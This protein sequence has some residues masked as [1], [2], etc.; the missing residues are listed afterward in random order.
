LGRGCEI[1]EAGEAEFVVGDASY[2]TRFTLLCR[3]D[4]DMLGLLHG[5]GA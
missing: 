3:K 1:D 5:V 2:W 4:F